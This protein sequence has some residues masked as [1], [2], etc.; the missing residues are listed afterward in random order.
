MQSTSPVP[1]MSRYEHT[2]PAMLQSLVECALEKDPVKR[3]ANADAFIN[4]LNNIALPISNKKHKDTPD[5]LIP[6]APSISLTAEMPPLQ[7]DITKS[8]M[9]IERSSGISQV[10]TEKPIPNVPTEEGV[11]AYLRCEMNGDQPQHFAITQKS[12]I[13]GR[14]HPKRGVRPDIDLTPLDRTMT[15]SPLHARIRFEETFFYIEDLKSRNKTRLGELI[16][17]P[18]KAELLQHGDSIYLQSYA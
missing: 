7:G 10:A 18:L 12:M 14:Q 1:S 9:L 15:I 17:T 4:A 6:P 3:F 5:T 13:V 2:T 8:T 16:L 11:Y